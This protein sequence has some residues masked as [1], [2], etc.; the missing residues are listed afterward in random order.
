MGGIPQ[1]GRRKSIQI[2]G[3]F[4]M[5]HFL[6][7][8]LLA[9][10]P[11]PGQE[12]GEV[13]QLR[14]GR[15]AEVAVSEKKL[16]AAAGLFE[17]AVREDHLRG[18][19]IMVVRDHRV[20]LHEAHGWR[21]LQ[22][23]KAMGKD[24]L[25][26]MASNTKA[27]VATAVLRLADAGRIAL[28]DPVARYIESFDHPGARSITIRHLL[29]HTSGLRIK[30]IFI[31]PL[32]QKSPSHPHAP[33]L[34][35]E[36]ARFGR[37]G[38]EKTPGTTYSYSNPGYNTLGA[39][40]EVVSG[41]SLKEYLREEIY[42]P[43]GMADSCNHEIDADHSRMSAIFRPDKKRKGAWK[44]GWKPGDKPDYPFPRASGG[45]ISTAHDF[46]VFCQMF[47]DGGSQGSGRILSGKMVGEATRSQVAHIDGAKGYGLGWRVEDDG[48]FSHG[49]SDGTWA[50]VDPQKKV[51]GIVFTQSP[52]GANPR[53]EFK[54]L[55]TAACGSFQ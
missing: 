9:A 3:I 23:K 44:V 36:V 29:S 13:H 42:R 33:S 41:R 51:I 35:D 7:I 21:D 8:L 47:L 40:V 4:V 6:I 26:R 43:L 34:L 27:V 24:S 18:A 49:G 30:P 12:A 14:P 54:R 55:V 2:T 15:P 31:R 52:G 38:S 46:A 53:A 1:N 16:A 32:V 28:D 25:F 20:I 22:Q 19:V 5:R 17:K 37:I 10:G 50:W 11:L 45:M 39:L 48:V